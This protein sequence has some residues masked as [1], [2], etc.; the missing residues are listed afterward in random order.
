[1]PAVPPANATEASQQATTKQLTIRD[2]RIQESSGLAASRSLPGVLWTV[3]DSGGEPEVYG[4]GPDGRT[5]LT[6]RLDGAANRD[7][8]AVSVGPRPG[9]RS[10]LWAADIGDNN[11]VWPTIRVYR[12]AEPTV[13]EDQVAA[14]TAYDLRY[15][16]GPRDAETLLVDPRSGRLYV[17]SKRVQGAAIYQAPASL[18]AGQVNQLTR[19]ASAGPLLT[20]G[21][22]APDGRVALRGYL[23]A[24]VAPGIGK[25]ATRL[26]LP[27]QPQ[28]ESLTWQLDGSAVLVG[29]EGE[30]S[31]VWRVPVPATELESPSISPKPAPTSGEAP[32]DDALAPAREGS[33]G[34]SILWV[35]AAGLLLGGGLAWAA[36]VRRRR[37]HSS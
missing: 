9:G 17:V 26:A 28:G 1:M 20:D 32:P 12:V 24:T 2:P 19:V 22:F 34:W 21:A 23:G 35:G 18:R 14:W 27:L 6:V 11:S 15:P 30:R 36:A 4:V 7:W 16:D 25:K 10:W 31:A 29:S 5:A 33:S 13:A 3:N 8:E 37:S